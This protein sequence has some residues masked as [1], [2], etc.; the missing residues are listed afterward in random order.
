MLIILLIAL[1]ALIVDQTTKLLVLN[2]MEEFQEITIIDGFFS[3][4][5]T[6]NNGAA[7]SMQ[8]PYWI[9]ILITVVAIGA[10]IYFSRKI[11]YRKQKWLTA[12]IGLMMGGTLG[13]FIDRLFYPEHLVVDMLSF[14]LYYPNFK[15]GWSTYLFPIF[16]FADSFLVVGV[17]MFIVYILFLDPS[18]KK[19][20][21]KEKEDSNES[22]NI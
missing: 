18:N 13:N 8:I 9:L 2:L 12:T 6:R 1:G 17:I 19:P 20:K 10:F 3:I 7:W 16:N 4:Y 21:E 22:K 11:D 15:D 5:S 14:T